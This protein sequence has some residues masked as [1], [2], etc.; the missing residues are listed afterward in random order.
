[1]KNFSQV[2]GMNESS[3][4]SAALPVL[5]C[6]DTHEARSSTFAAY[7]ALLEKIDNGQREAIY[8]QAQDAMTFEDSFS[9]LPVLLSLHRN[10]F[11]DDDTFLRVLGEEWSGFDNIGEYLH[12][13]YVTLSDL[14]SSPDGGAAV[15]PEMM[16]PEEQAA[17]Y[18]LPETFTVYR[19]CYRF[20]KRGLS[21]SLKQEVAAE[22]PTLLRY[23]H[24]GE[25][26]ILITAKVK[27]ADVIAL[28][29]DRGEFEIIAYRTKHVSTRKIADFKWCS[30][31]L[32]RRAFKAY[33]RSNETFDPTQPS[34]SLSG[35]EMIDGLPYVVLRN[36]DGILAV[37][38]VRMKNGQPGLNRL[39]EW[40]EGLDE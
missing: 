4:V 1:M 2:N 32:E 5:D 37:Y 6:N 21:W 36:C 16:T 38:R 40:P 7:I 10:H 14:C 31:D 25:Q 17:L 39:E 24:P 13:V 28:K 30:A 33:L 11:I 18:D 23:T 20:N 27:K 35:F 8:K 3:P 19:G 29:M 22:F 34:Q 15:M 12:E 26:A 9:R